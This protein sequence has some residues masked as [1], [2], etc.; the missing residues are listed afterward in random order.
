MT[1][2]Y[3]LVGIAGSGM[4]A[5]AEVLLDGGAAV[6]GSDR[7]LDGGELPPAA[8]A[9]RAQGVEL[10]AQDASGVLSRRRRPDAVVASAAVESDN[11][12][13]A[14]ARSAGIPVLGRSEALALALE[15]KRLVAVAGTCGKST[16]TALLGH[17]LHCAGLNPAVVNGASC[18]A[19]TDGG[20]R[21]GAVLRGGGGICVAEVDE[22]DKSLLR[23]RP[24]AAIVLN[25]SADHFPIEETNALFDAFVSRVE[26]G[27]I[28]VDARR[29]PPPVARENGWAVEF[30]FGGASLSLPCPG[31]HNAADA[32]AACRMATALGVPASALAPALAS[33]PGISRRMQRVGR[34]SGG[35]VVV[36]DYAHNTEKLRSAILALQARSGRLFAVWR[37]HGYAPLRKM[38]GDLAKMFAETLRAGDALFLLPVFDAG[39]TAD[40]SIASADLARDLSGAPFA[41]FQAADA[42]EAAAR[43]G[44]EAR[45]GDIAAVFGARDPGLARLARALA[46][47]PA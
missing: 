10:F 36:D 4:S 22:S 47:R 31:L 13:V 9:L 46:V 18:P 14:A 19:W 28:V 11:P 26:K 21:T 32:V 1:G 8:A 15:G 44:A 2:S 3:H 20:R 45:D 24:A 37:P 30:E 16:T 23:F 42:D 7:F 38:R 34:T 39:G 33:F 35:A 25:A 29:D 40:R 17:L 41:V 27:G 5:L 43:I 12:D 6:S